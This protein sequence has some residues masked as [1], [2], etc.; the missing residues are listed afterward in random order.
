MHMI[1]LAVTFGLVLHV[2][3][4]DRSNKLKSTIGPVVLVKRRGWLR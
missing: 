3:K 4:N 1:N 2:N